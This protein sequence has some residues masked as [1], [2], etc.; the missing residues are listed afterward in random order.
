MSQP[1]NGASSLHRRAALVAGAV[2]VVAVLAVLIGRY[3]RPGFIP[4]QDLGRDPLAARILFGLRLPRVL[5]ALLVGAALAASG[6]VLQMLFANPLVEPGLVGVTQGAAFGAA[7][8]IVAF[9]APPIVVQLSAAFFAAAGLGVS[10]HVA[11]KIRFGGWVLR[12]VL[13]G[14][15]VSAIFSAGVGML[16]YVA[17]PMDQLPA[18]TFWMLGGLWAIGWREL[19]YLLP[20]V[21]PALAVLFAMRWR[22]NLLS[23][24]DRVAF[25]LGAAPGRER[26][27]LL[28]CA[29]VATA[30][31]TSVAG[32]V[33]W[34]GLLI[35][36]IARRLFRA[37]GRW[38][39]PASI[40]LGAAF[41]AACDTIGRSL[42]P[43]EIPLGILTS[44]FGAA[45]FVILL[46]RPGFRIER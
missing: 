41:V 38:S 24:N 30:A 42:L 23:L 45:G 27:V 22:A 12:L 25:S 39:V 7:L 15:A 40:G 34:V 19:L 9:S 28:A 4:L 16:K 10:Y 37:D 18:I 13:S 46:A 14:I 31:V 5:A 36:H 26:L 11:R 17:D 3:P 33:G 29:T 44:L 43:G 20:T 21:L 6:T 32:I 35:P 1:S 8:A 2:I